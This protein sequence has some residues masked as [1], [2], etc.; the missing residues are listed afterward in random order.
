ME[1]RPSIF[2]AIPNLGNVATDNM[3]NVLN[4]FMSGRYDLKIFA[5]QGIRPL[6]RARNLCHKAF[7]EDQVRHDYLFFMDANTIPPVDILDRLLAH[8]VPMVAGTVQIWNAEYKLMPMALRRN[9]ALGGYVPHVGEGLQD[10][11]VTTCACTLI[12]RHVMEQVRCPAFAFTHEDEYGI[13]GLSEDFYFCEGVKAAGLPIGVDF[14]VV[15]DHD[16]HLRSLEVNR[17]LVMSH[18]G[19]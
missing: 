12:K 7:L 10:V 2:I 19:E 18:G 4:W 16:L 11:D 8:D 13:D 6:D 5:P 17:A 14:D 9:D 1:S 15:C 3:M